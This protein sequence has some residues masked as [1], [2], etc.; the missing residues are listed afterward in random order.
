MILQE[1][2]NLRKNCPMCDA[3]LITKFDAGRKSKHRLENDR[4]ISVLVMR[5]MRSCEP[6]YEVGYSFGLND[7]SLAIEFYNEWDMRNHAST[8]MCDLFKKFHS[9]MKGIRWH[10]TRTCGFCFKYEISTKPIEIDLKTATF[11]PLEVEDETFVWAFPTEDGQH[12]YILLDNHRNDANTENISELC[13]WRSDADYRVEWPVPP[14]YSIKRDL[15][16]IPFIS[17]EETGR[18]VSNLLIFS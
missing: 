9:N 2:I 3:G 16:L 4:L 5:G 17:E 6:D 8:Y 7:N 13:W 1:F 10:F 14:N 12:R 11:T 18:R 15:P